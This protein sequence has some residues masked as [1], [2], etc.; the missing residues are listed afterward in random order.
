MT[1]GAAAVLKQLC[2]LRVWHECLRGDDGEAL[3]ENASGADYVCARVLEAKGKTLMCMRNGAS[4]SG[5]IE[6]LC[7]CVCVCASVCVRLCVCA[8]LC[9]C[10]VLQ[11]GH[12]ASVRVVAAGGGV[13]RRAACLRGGTRGWKRRC[14]FSPSAPAVWRL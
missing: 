8:C 12:V 2:V 3:A 5:A 9:L 6:S 11:A 7:K 10:F 13:R 14:L 4:A 1:S